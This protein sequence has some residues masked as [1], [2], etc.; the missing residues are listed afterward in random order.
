MFDLVVQKQNVNIPALSET[1]Q[2]KL[3]DAISGV[4]QAD[5]Q[6]TVHFFDEPSAEQRAQA[7]QIVLAHDP[8]VLTPVQR[9]RAN[10][11]KQLEQLRQ[12]AAELLPLEAFADQPALI[13]T[14]AQKVALLELELRDLQGR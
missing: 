10:R 13:R 5:G 8:A 11:Q 12:Q 1:C 14:L 2:A 6:I 7:E 3:G 9:E 4:S